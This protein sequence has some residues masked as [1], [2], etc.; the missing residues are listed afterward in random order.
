MRSGWQGSG[1]GAAPHQER[2]M[3]VPSPDTPD[4]TPCATGIMCIKQFIWFG[5]IRDS[6][7]C[8]GAGRREACSWRWMPAERDEVESTRTAVETLGGD[9]AEAPR[10]ALDL[11][12]HGPRTRSAAGRWQRRGKGQ[13]GQRRAGESAESPAAGLAAIAAQ[14]ARLAP[15]HRA[16]VSSSMLETQSRNRTRSIVLLPIVNASRNQVQHMRLRSANRAFG[17]FIGTNIPA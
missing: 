7:A 14:T 11:D 4:T 3:N 8:P 2:N 13:P 17:F 9:A 1:H 10:E 5:S 6:Q 16:A 12:V 15:G